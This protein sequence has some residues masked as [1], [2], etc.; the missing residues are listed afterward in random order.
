[1]K[2]STLRLGGATAVVR[3]NNDTTATVID[4]YEDVSALLASTDWKAVAQNASGQT[5]DLVTADYAPVVPNPGKIVCVGLNYA[6]HIK[7]MGR[8]LPEY[9]TLFAKFA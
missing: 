2:V 9:P 7:E 1:M 6:T 4:G 5:L 3:V 8:E